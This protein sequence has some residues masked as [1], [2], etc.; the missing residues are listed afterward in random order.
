VLEP[1]GSYE[2]KVKFWKKIIRVLCPLKGLKTRMKVCFG[3]E[4]GFWMVGSQPFSHVTLSKAREDTHQ[5]NET[6][7]TYRFFTVQ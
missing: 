4:G 2:S 1:S 6:I 7:T 3:G 5:K